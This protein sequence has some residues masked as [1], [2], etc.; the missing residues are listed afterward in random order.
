MILK[1]FNFIST[2]Q[3]S[4]L[5]D[6]IWITHLDFEGNSTTSFS[7]IHIQGFNQIP[8]VVMEGIFQ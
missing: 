8:P 3:L 5:T 2:F 4:L 6:Q 7:G 1:I